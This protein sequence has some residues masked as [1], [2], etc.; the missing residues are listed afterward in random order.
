MLSQCRPEVAAGDNGHGLSGPAERRLDLEDLLA[1]L[2][3]VGF[4]EEVATGSD[5]LVAVFL[6]PGHDVV[7]DPRPDLSGSAL[8]G[9]RYCPVGRTLRW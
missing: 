8:C 2:G 9:S 3:V 7:H 6:D 1:R 5:V 4:E